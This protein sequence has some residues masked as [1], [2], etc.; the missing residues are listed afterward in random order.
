MACLAI[1]N[2]VSRNKGLC[3]V[4]LSLGVEEL[5]NSVD[6]AA[7]WDEAKAALRDLGCNVKLDEPFTGKGVKLSHGD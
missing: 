6:K 5:L 7:C 4:F 3:S 1:R 2:L